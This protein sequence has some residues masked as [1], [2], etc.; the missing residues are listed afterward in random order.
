MIASKLAFTAL[1]AAFA[2]ASAAAQDPPAPRDVRSELKETMKT[3][4]PLLEQAR[5]AGKVAETPGG[6]VKLVKASFAGDKVDPKDAAKG[7]VGELVDS[8]NKDRRLLYELLGKELKLTAAAVGKQN[9]LRNVDKAKPEH[10]IEVDG[11][12]VQR[13]SVV[14][15][16]PE[17]K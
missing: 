12:L 9:G 16:D 7:T 8:E 1:L 17:K 6:E 2:T 14:P 10:W 13:K 5:D 4:Y 3:R 11:K 15:K